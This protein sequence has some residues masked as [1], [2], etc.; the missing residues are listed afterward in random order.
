V[1]DLPSA[2]AADLTALEYLS[3]NELWEVMSSRVSNEQQRKLNRLLRKKK[4]DTLASAEQSELSSLQHEADR[5]MLR[6]ARAAVLLRF[7]GHRLPTL[8]ELRK[9]TFARF[10]TRFDF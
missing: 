1:K 4:N 9:L 8:S 10:L 3:D 5:I 7:R 6:K 2:L